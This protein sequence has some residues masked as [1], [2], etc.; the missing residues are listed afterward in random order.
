MLCR[1]LSDLS[2]HLS[3]LTATGIG[4]YEGQ[5]FQGAHRPAIDE[6]PV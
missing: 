5:L 4:N 2:N 1:L 6:T 3:E